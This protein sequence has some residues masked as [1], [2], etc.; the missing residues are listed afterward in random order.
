MTLNSAEVT[1]LI[2][3]DHSSISLFIGKKITIALLYF[4]R[5]PHHKFCASIDKYYA[6]ITPNWEMLFA[7]YPEDLIPQI[8]TSVTI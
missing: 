5:V 6:K 3:N 2:Y 1:L 4:T 7:H 8:I